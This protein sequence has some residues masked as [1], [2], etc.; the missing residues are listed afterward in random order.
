[1]EKKNNKRRLINAIS[2]YEN[3]H[4]S[5]IHNKTNKLLFDTIFIGLTTNRENL[6]NIINNRVDIMIKKGLIDEVK[7]FYNQNIRSKPLLGGIGYKE[8][9]NYFDNQCTLEE[10]IENIKRNSRRYAKKQYTFFN[11]QLPIHWIE[12]D[13]K[14]FN[15]TI[16]Q[17]KKY[18][19]TII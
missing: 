13:Y 10:T 4:T 12:T 2:Y 7:N 17:T 5:I 14:N 9:Y 19:D 8:L 1:M 6:Y 3:N 15:N 11:H 18:I 16:N